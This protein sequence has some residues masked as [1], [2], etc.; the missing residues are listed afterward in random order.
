[1]ENIKIGVPTKL[2]DSN[3]CT[4]PSICKLSKIIH[5]KRER[6]SKSI[7]TLGYFKHN[8]VYYRT[9]IDNTPFNHSEMKAERQKAY[10]PEF[11]EFLKAKESQQLP[12]KVYNF[13]PFTNKKGHRYAVALFSDAHI[14]ETVIPESVNFLNEY[15]VDIAE[16]RIETYFKNLA[17][18]LA[19]DEVDELIFASLGDTISGYI[20][21]EL[22]QTNQLSPLEATLK[23]QSLV[24]SG[25]KYLYESEQ[26]PK[27]KKI[28]FIGIV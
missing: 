26:L 13:E 4:Y 8:G 21:Q 7:N 12:F 2:V 17:S 27:L 18:C 25:L 11:E 28:R 16:K 6:I 20:H 19:Q 24:Y 9:S 22:E 5:V 10:E 3:G 1:M 23:A 15:N 14:E